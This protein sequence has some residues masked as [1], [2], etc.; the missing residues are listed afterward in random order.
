MSSNF[1]VI[2]FTT[3]LVMAAGAMKAEISPPNI[4]CLH[5]MEAGNCFLAPIFEHSHSGLQVIP[6]K[7]AHHLDKHPETNHAWLVLSV[8]FILFCMLI[9]IGYSLIVKNQRGAKHT[10]LLD[11]IGRLQPIVPHLNNTD[12]HTYM[13]CNDANSHAQSS[14]RDVTVNPSIG[15]PNGLP[16]NV[17][18]DLK[19]ACTDT[20]TFCIIGYDGWKCEVALPT[21]LLRQKKD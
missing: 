8:P 21:D 6:K 4:T 16:G 20:Q 14:P 15:G 12:W 10:D 7:F 9:K 18:S 3:L 5:D 13:R 1:T 17:S 11:L 19:D 2:A